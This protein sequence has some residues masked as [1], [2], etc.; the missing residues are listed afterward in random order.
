MGDP[1]EPRH[2]IDQHREAPGDRLI[3]QW[4]HLAINNTDLSADETAERI[5]AW[6]VT[7]Q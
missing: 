2:N 3:A 5:L 4:P 1:G 6:L 7:D